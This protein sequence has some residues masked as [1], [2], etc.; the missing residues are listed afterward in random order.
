MMTSVR[1]SDGTEIAFDRYGEGRPVILVGGIIQH[2]AI[3]PQ[4]A[5]LARRLAERFSVYHYDRRGRGE[6]TDTPPWS[7]EREVEDLAALVADAGG[8]AYAFGMS[9]GGGLVLEA[10]ARGVAL[11]RIAVYEPP[12]DAG[13]EDANPDLPGRLAELTA[14][15]RNGDAV[16]LFFER[17]GMPEDA[18]AQMR[19]APISAGFESVAPT[20]VYDTTMMADR[21]LLAERVP[22]VAAPLLVIEGGASESWVRDAVAAVARAVPHARRHTI[23]GQTHEVDP[24]ALAPVLLDFFSA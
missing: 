7:V 13:E 2:R 5:Q 1:S 11:E 21:T 3:D 19:A 9:S 24:D 12:F 15:G 18:V 8:A 17:A 4:T 6:S 22:T 20:M 16:A 23:E 14:A 10:A